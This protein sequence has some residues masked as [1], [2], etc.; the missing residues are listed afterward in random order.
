MDMRACSSY[1]ACT[2]WAIVDGGINNDGEFGSGPSMEDFVERERA[3]GASIIIIGYPPTLGGA[4]GPTYDAMMES[5]ATLAAAS[6]DVY[7]VDP[8][9]HPI[10]GDPGNPDSREWR[11][12][13]NEHPSPLAGE[14]LANEAA[15]YILGGG[16]GG[17]GEDQSSEEDQA[18]EDAG[19]EEVTGSDYGGSSSKK[20][21]EKAS[22]SI[23][24]PCVIAAVVLVAAVLFL[25]R[26]RTVAKTQRHRASMPAVTD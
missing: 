8:R 17:G 19:E 24:I 9:T 11:A 25:I 10:M 7:F 22:L 2:K 13:D 15:E 12:G 5:F 3:A 20:K 21:K 16:G 26:K 4:S 6:D 23:I 18:S 1:D 14:W